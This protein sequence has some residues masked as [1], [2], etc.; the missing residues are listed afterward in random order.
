MKHLTDTIRA[1]LTH[2]R[3]GEPYLSETPTAAALTALA[4][5]ERLA[6]EPVARLHVTETDT[7]PD[8]DVEVINGTWLQ[9]KMSPISVYVATPPAQQ[10]HVP[11]AD[12]LDTNSLFADFIAQHPGLREELKAMD[13][14]Q[15]E[16]ISAF[17]RSEREGWEE[18]EPKPQ[19]K[20]ALADALYALQVPH[21]A[22]QDG[23]VTRCMCRKCVIKRG[24]E[25]LA[26]S[27][28]AEAAPEM[29]DALCPALTGGD[30]T[31]TPPATIDKAWAQF[32]G[33]I[34]RG[35][36]APYP[37]M[38]EAFEAHYGQ[39]F[40]DKDWRKETGVWA[41]AWKAAKAHGEAAPQQAEAVPDWNA[42]CHSA[43]EWA[44]MAINGLQW[45]RNIVDG[46]S[47]P[48]EALANMESCLKH[49]REVNDA[50][51]VQNAVRVAAAPQQAEAVPAHRCTGAGDT[52]LGTKADCPFC[53]APQQAEAVPS[54]VVRDAER[55]RTFLATRPANTHEVI[56]QAIDDAAT[57]KGGG[58]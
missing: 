41:A 32:C 54:D 46:I 43:N 4:E 47:D 22:C 28:Q 35:P 21:V 48:K 16:G 36:D 51:A 3:E 2:R 42:L 14:Q 7:Y 58:V 6:G 37:G 23:L 19:T 1:G 56:N 34:G 12:C 25:A 13:E 52:A 31:C 26:A 18:R 55:W 53:A 24:D 20:Q 5:L 44:D 57:K 8:I 11:E 45:L 30:C 10:P 9:P 33:G 15:A 40:T 50:P 39:T 38:I 49:C 29:H 27:Q 17:L